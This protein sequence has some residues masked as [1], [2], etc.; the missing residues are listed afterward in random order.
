MFK[1]VNQFIANTRIRKIFATKFSSFHFEY[2]FNIAFALCSCLLLSAVADA[3]RDSKWAWSSSKNQNDV[4]GPRDRPQ[5]ERRKFESV[6][7]FR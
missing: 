3:Q 5:S 7:D 2:Y 1:G 4:N 6:E